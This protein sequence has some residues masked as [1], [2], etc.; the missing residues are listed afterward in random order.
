MFSIYHYF[1]LFD[2]ICNVWRNIM[3]YSGTMVRGIKAPIIRK[4]DN[5]VQIVNNCLINI[6]NNENIV[7]NDGDIVCITESI[8]A[9]SQNNY[10]TTSHIAK[11]VSEVFKDDVVGLVFPILSRNR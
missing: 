3:K 6:V 4:G 1:N 7:L 10:A 9:I 8:V 2:I 5:I 11:S